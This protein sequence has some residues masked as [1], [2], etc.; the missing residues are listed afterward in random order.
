MA[1]SA[2]TTWHKLAQ[3][4]S[5][6][7]MERIRYNAKGSKAERRFGRLLRDY[8]ITISLWQIEVGDRK[9][10]LIAK[11]ENFILREMAESRR[12]FLFFSFFFSCVLLVV[13]LWRFLRRRRCGFNEERSGAGYRQQMADCSQRRSEK[14]ELSSSKR[15]KYLQTI[16][17]VMN[18]VENPCDG[19]PDRTT[20]SAS[21]RLRGR[22]TLAR[23]RHWRN[24]NENKK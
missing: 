19:R 24:E 15:N 10:H 8:K 18:D 16:T 5:F 14:T 17:K 1:S 9:Q 3:R 11:I 12:V 6:C 20:H 4:Y 22:W 2:T 21:R 7:H 23:R 13:I